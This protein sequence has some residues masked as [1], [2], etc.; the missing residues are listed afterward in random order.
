MA[1]ARHSSRENK[2]IIKTSFAIFGLGVA[3]LTYK[4]WGMGTMPVC[5]LGFTC[6]ALFYASLLM[7]A[8]VSPGGLLARAFRAR[9]LMWLGTIAYALC[10]FHEIIL[11]AVFRL[12]LH[13]T[14]MMTNEFDA[15]TALL[16]LVVALSLAQL[17]WKYFES[18]LVKIGHRFA[19]GS[20]ATTRSPA[21]N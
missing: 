20:R 6:V 15:L 1:I 7:I 13:H 9:W 14:P 16:A 8:M 19:Y 10:L 18:K 21:P 11:D 17:S 2:W 5:T 4:G 3:V 12:V